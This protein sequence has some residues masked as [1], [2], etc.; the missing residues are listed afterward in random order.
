MAQ[1]H[2]IDLMA[3]TV[4]VFHFIAGYIIDGHQTGVSRVL[5][6]GNHASMG[7]RR[8]QSSALSAVLFAHPFSGA[9]ATFCV[10]TRWIT[11]ERECK[12]IV[13]ACIV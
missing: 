1:T 7:V 6:L 9:S 13:C 12:V 5:R 3:F 10:E 8:G 2:T 11:A 4:T